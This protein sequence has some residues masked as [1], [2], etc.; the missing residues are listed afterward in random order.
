MRTRAT[1]ACLAGLFAGHAAPGADRLSPEELAVFR[2]VE[3]ARIEVTQS[4]A[5]IEYDDAKKDAKPPEHIPYAAE[6]ATALQFAGWR[7]AAPGAPA[8]V[9]VS[10]GSNARALGGEYTGT[11][12]GHHYSGAAVNGELALRHRAGPETGG[13]FSG[14]IPPPHVIS[15][16]YSSQ[17]QAPYAETLPFYLETLYV[18]LAEIHGARVPLA[19]LVSAETG[20]QGAAMNALRKIVTEGDAPLLRPLVAHKDP[21]VA[22]CAIFLLGIAGEPGDVAGLIPLL[23]QEDIERADVS[24][25]PE[26]IFGDLTRVAF[27]R[28]SREDR[29]EA[30]GAVRPDDARLAAEWA[31]A[32][33]AGPEHAPLFTATLRDSKQPATVR[34]GAALALGRIDHPAAVEALLAA[35]ADPSPLVRAAAANALAALQS[36]SAAAA[37]SRVAEDRDHRVAEAARRALAGHAW[38]RWDEFKRRDPRPAQEA[39]RIAAALRSDDALLRLGAVLAAQ[40]ADESTRDTTL[41]A[42]LGDPAA[43]VRDAAAIWLAGEFRDNTPETMVALLADPDVLTSRRAFRALVA[44][45]NVGEGE[46]ISKLPPLPAKTAPALLRLAEGAAPQEEVMPLLERVEGDGAADAI[47]EY[48]R[49]PAGKR[50]HALALLELARR[51]D[52]RALAPMLAALE[53]PAAGEADHLLPASLG[54]AADEPTLDALIKHLKHPEPLVRRRAAQALG[55][56]GKARAVGPLIMALKAAEEAGTADAQASL[57]KR[58][59]D[60]ALRNLTGQSCGDS[61]DWLEWW[62]KN[63]GKPLLQPSPGS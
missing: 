52:R 30:A 23:R 48:C 26:G 16:Y 28:L 42:A 57:L 24:E 9:T 34:R 36:G 38:V 11:V 53:N 1:I 40:S 8:D 4:Y 62:R 47:F 35:L 63:A 17:S 6:T 45:G 5:Y 3:T 18:A 51:G 22:R 39:G 46:D 59:V 32:Q 21:L 2:K 14:E 37:L 43:I 31:V 54:K 41:E 7:I 25:L 12:S 44:M 58:E 13:S 20:H 33:L 60:E 56:C 61:R 50:S 29:R 55:N 19:A 10:V 15:R 49:R 27:E